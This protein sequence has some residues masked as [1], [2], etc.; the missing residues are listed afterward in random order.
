MIFLI[1]LAVLGMTVW[2]VCKCGKRPGTAK[3]AQ[4]KKKNPPREEPRLAWYDETMC[5]CCFWPLLWKGT[6]SNTCSGWI[7]SLQCR[8]FR[9]VCCSLVFLFL[10][11]GIGLLLEYAEEQDPMHRTVA[12]VWEMAAKERM[13]E[14]NAEL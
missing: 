4:R 1:A 8:V 10:M 9:C 3:Q 13:R 11:A 2:K 12:E 5:C 6:F 14:L 7:A